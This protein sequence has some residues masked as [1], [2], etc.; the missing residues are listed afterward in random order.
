VKEKPQKFLI[1]FSFYE[2]KVLR[3]KERTV[4]AKNITAAVERIKGEYKRF[5]KIQI[6]KWQQL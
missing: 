6:N 1:C 4:E 2:G 5:G 3:T